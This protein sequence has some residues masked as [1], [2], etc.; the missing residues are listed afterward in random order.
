[1]EP[2][3]L[4]HLTRPDRARPEPLSVQL[5]RDLLAAIAAGRAQGSLPSSRAAAEALG[6]S[7][8]TVNAAYDLLRAEGAVATSPGAPPRIIAPPVG[9]RRLAPNSRGL[10]QLHPR[11]RAW[12]AVERSGPGLMAP[13]HPDP[14]LFPRDTWAMALRRA[15][16][17][18]SADSLGYA[19][20]SGLPR[21]R[22]VLARRLAADRGM[23][24]HPD[25]ILV[26][27]GSQ[28]SLALLALTLAGPG[29]P[30]LVE[31]PGYGGAKAAFAGAGLVPMPI[32]VDDE[33]AD[34]RQAPPARLVYLTPANQY[35]LGCR[36]SLGRREMILAYAR[37]HEAVLI[38][39][40]YDSEFLW[41]G[42]A[43]A[44]LQGAAPERVA[45]I[46]TV[47]KALMPALRLG[48]IAAPAHLAPGLR[49][50]QRNL[51]LAA[52]LHVQAALAEMIEQG[53]YR[54]HLHRIAR[55]YGD[56]GRAFAAALRALPGVRVGDP[57][58]GVQLAMRL[59]EGTEGLAHAALRAAGFGCA[60]LSGFCLGAPRSGLVSGF[61]EAT[62][63]RIA[64]FCAVLGQVLSAQTAP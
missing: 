54:A 56:R 4:L 25:Q 30:V 58:G 3:S 6:L 14:A 62:P 46:G 64:R 13:G 27:P 11:G 60:P 31:D 55:I 12:G 32:P 40:D 57:A 9:D 17:Q 33:G 10:P 38:E 20:Y 34:C 51:G 63:E 18:S 2:A 21:L 53:H 48:W 5:Y 41:Q 43:I 44:A 23:D 19:E 16:R 15:T 59:P 24:L 22:E 37:Q 26:T 45:C 49:A 50:A 47:A 35:P 28:S 1:M 7:R 42:R 29:D 61:A 8:N 39:D 52:N 36:L